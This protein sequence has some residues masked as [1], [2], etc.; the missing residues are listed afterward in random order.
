M[1]ERKY[2]APSK[3]GTLKGPT[4]N[5][6]AVQYGLCGVHRLSVFHPMMLPI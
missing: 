2:L 5:M 3:D 6:D 1:T 4:T